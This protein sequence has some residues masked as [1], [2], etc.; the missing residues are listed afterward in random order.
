MIDGHCRREGLI[1][2]DLS[3]P[4]TALTPPRWLRCRRCG[5]ISALEAGAQRLGTVECRHCRASLRWECPVCKRVSWLDEPRCP[6]G[7]GVEWLEPLRQHLDAAG[8]AHKQHDDRTALEHLELVLAIAPQHPGARKGVRELKQRLAEVARVRAQVELERTRRRLVAARAALDAW[9]KLVP[10]GDIELNEVRAGIET[11]L[12]DAFT[13][14]TQGQDLLHADP[15]AARMLFRKSLALAAD[16]PEA[17]D[18]L[19]RCPPDPPGDLQAD[20]DGHRVRLRWAAAPPDGLGAVSYRVV[21]KRGGRPSHA[22]DGVTLGEVS[23]TEFED[24]AAPPGDWVGYAVFAGRRET[25]SRAG[26]SAEPLA[27]LKDVEDPRIETQDRDVTLSWTL[28]EPALGVRVLRKTGT[29]PDGLDDGTPID[30]LKEE[31][32][33]RGL[34]ENQVYYYAIHVLYRMPDGQTLASRG[35]TLAAEPQASDQQVEKLTPAL[36]DDGRVRLNWKPVAAGR[37]LILRRTLPLDLAP[38]TR[39]PADRAERLEGTWIEV[40]GPDHAFDPRPPVSGLCYYLPLTIWA[41][42]ATVGPAAAFA[43]LLEPADLRA[44]AWAAQD[45]SICAGAGVR[46]VPARSSWRASGH[47]PPARRTPRPCV[48]RS[49]KPNTAGSAPIRSTCRPRAEASGTWRS[50]ACCPRTT[51]RSPPPAATA[52]R[53]RS[54]PALCPKSRSAMPFGPRVSRAV[55]GPFGSAPILPARTS[56]PRPWWLTPAPCPSRSRTATSSTSSRPPATVPHFAS[57]AV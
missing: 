50:S 47:F 41:G 53:A 37:V 15:A 16:L 42:K 55:P 30:A 25:V 38:G 34:K 26:A 21:R 17:H 28:P 56:R 46:P 48:S 54:C 22:G 6:C 33:D 11:I 29:A 36:L 5:G 1:R 2:D 18:G 49:R 3:G 45:G 13:L 4:P 19:R 35:V 51:V 8:Q 39:L 57:E 7:F 24:A 52:P 44:C 40:Q 31:A 23:G 20:F 27:V 10:A 32:N 14:A 12:G 9:E 43:N